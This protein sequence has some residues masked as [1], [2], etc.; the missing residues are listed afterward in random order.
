MNNDFSEK[1]DSILSN[2]AMMAQI[3]AL[4]DTMIQGKPENEPK[5]A[6]PTPPPPAQEKEPPAMPSVPPFFTPSPAFEKNLKNTCT[7]LNALK[8]FLDENRCS[9]IDKML[10]MI[11]FAEMAGQFSNFF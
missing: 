6:E 5:E 7:L 10:S 1:L 9:K 4:A 11:R 3:K 8:P 2:P